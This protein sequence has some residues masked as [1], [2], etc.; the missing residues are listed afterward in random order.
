MLKKPAGKGRRVTKVVGYGVVVVF[1]EGIDLLGTIEGEAQHVVNSLTVIT[2][3]WLVTD[4]DR[5]KGDV[6]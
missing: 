1:E 4:R 3:W 2:F 5:V 6:F